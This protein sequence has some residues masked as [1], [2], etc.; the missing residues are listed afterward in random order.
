MPCAFS[1]QLKMS[2]ATFHSPLILLFLTLPG[3]QLFILTYNCFS[4]YAHYSSQIIKIYL[5][6]KILSE[7]LEGVV[8]TQKPRFTENFEQKGPISLRS[9]TVESEQS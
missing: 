5:K 3:I 1:L 2:P 7:T 6:S 9:G 4:G 8:E